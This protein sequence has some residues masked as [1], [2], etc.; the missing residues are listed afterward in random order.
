MAQ[1]FNNNTNLDAGEY[2]N[3]KKGLQ[4]YSYF[5]NN[6]RRFNPNK[7]NNINNYNGSAYFK[8]QSPDRYNLANSNSYDYLL[9]INKGAQVNSTCKTCDTSACKTCDTSANISPD[10]I[11][12]IHYTIEQN[13]TVIDS[14]YINI[15]PS[16][17]LFNSTCDTN[18]NNNMIKSNMITIDPSYNNSKYSYKYYKFT[19]IP[20]YTS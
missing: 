11:N 16:G 19:N 8:K 18:L 4:N 17:K 6:I 20:V 9:S 1:F 12:G 10:L 7:F 15:D 14:S 5:Y 3:R 13:I 2:I